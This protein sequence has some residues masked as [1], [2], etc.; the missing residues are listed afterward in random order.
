[1][2]T[3]GPDQV[4]A[5]YPTAFITDT[6]TVQATLK[7][8]LGFA[9]L[10]SYS[11]WRLDD[12][13]NKNSLD[14][15]NLATFFINL[16]IRDR[17]IS[18]E[19][20]LT[21]KAGSALS[22]TAGLNYFQYRDNY[23][24]SGVLDT[25]GLFPA[26]TVVPYGG[27][28]TLSKSYAGFADA[29]YEVVPDKWFVTAGIR[30]SHDVVTDAFFYTANPFAASASAQPLNVVPDYS[31]NR[32]T[33]R[34]VLRYKPD[35]DS[36]VYV[37]FTKGYKAGILNVGGASFV[38]VQ[39][40]SISAFEGGYKYETRA[41]A[42]DL[43]GYYYDYKNLQVSS[44][45]GGLAQITNAASSEIYGFEA[46]GRYSVS[47]A[48]DLNAGLAYTHARY[49]SFA[50]APFY[51]Y[52][53]PSVA[54]AC[55]YGIAGGIVQSTTNASGYHVQR[56]PDFTANATA[57]YHVPLANGQF[58]ASGSFYYTS[59]FYFDPSQQFKQNGYATLGL[60][61]QW[62]DPSKRYTLAVYA[63]NV[64]NE[65]YKLAALQQTLGIGNVWNSPTTWGISLGTKF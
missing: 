26:G 58:T 60:R 6:D 10:T 12:S 5:K 35:H 31:S 21:S 14:P 11:Q 49:K 22:W 18:Q 19:F 62:V 33:P 48:F 34:I 63:D 13:L 17:T 55:A 65:R 40:E 54:G 7:A 36:S 32:A 53:D 44:F 24:V 64:T 15:D 57:A 43:A 42:I 1:L 29:T 52:C 45:T 30:Y 56:S 4:N 23:D 2:Y 8:D 47:S 27:S 3:T 50:N 9:N 37:S 28:G 61:A 25:A 39:P 38:P 51:G 41:F 59:S 20:V 46:Q 16:G